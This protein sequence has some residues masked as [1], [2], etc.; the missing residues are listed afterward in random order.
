MRKG[1]EE[2]QWTNNPQLICWPFL[3]VPCLGCPGSGPV[4]TSR[5]TQFHWGHQWYQCLGMCSHV[6]VYAHAC[7]CACAYMCLCM[8]GACTHACHLSEVIRDL[9]S[10][11]SVTGQ[12]A[13]PLRRNEQPSLSNYTHTISYELL[14]QN[15][16]RPREQLR[17][18]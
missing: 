7:V 9:Q 15:G 2:G 11:L 8:W 3:D 12:Q 1:R 6:C 4:L 10:I 13:L 14:L 18:Y 17:K 16:H 5:G